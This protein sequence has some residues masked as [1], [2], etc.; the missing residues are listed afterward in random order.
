MRQNCQRDVFTMHDIVTGPPKA[1]PSKGGTWKQR[2][3]IGCYVTATTV[4]MLGWLSAVTWA[5]AEIAKL[6]F[7]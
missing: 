5:A 1:S 2:V 3:L 6:L 4:A 7:A